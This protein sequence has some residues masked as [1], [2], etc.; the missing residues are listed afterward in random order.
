MIKGPVE[1]LAALAA[2]G[3]AIQSTDDGRVEVTGQG[4]T[5]EMGHACRRFKWVLSWGLHGASTG[6]RWFACDTCGMLNPLSKKPG[7]TCTMTLGCK[8]RSTEIPLP[9]FAPGFPHAVRELEPA[10]R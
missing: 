3:A 1:L 5:D 6:Y 2:A 7:K 8:G 4:L 9:R 10:V